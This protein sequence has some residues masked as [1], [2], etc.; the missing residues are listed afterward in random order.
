[1]SVKDNMTLSVKALTVESFLAEFRFK[2]PRK[3]NAKLSRINKK[4]LVIN[5]FARDTIISLK[6]F[7]RLWTG[8]LYYTTTIMRALVLIICL[9]LG[10]ALLVNLGLWQLKR[11]NEKKEITS[12]Y[13]QRK[14]S[15]PTR[16][17]EQ[18][19]LEAT[20]S[21]IWKNYQLS[22]RFL[23]KVYLLAVSYTHLTLPTTPYV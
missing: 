18:G 20:E 1:M 22:G 23:N 5:T 17:L 3:P 19:R 7:P 8:G 2:R 11:G 6:N 9:L 13:D 15:V 12:L 10:C 16:L 21:T 14:K 4:R